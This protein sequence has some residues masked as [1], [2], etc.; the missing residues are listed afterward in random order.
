MQFRLNNWGFVNERLST[1]VAVPADDFL[2]DLPHQPD[3]KS[4]MTC[5]GRVYGVIYCSEQCRPSAFLHL[6]SILPFCVETSTITDGYHTAR[7][8][9]KSPSAES[10]TT[11]DTNQFDPP[12]YGLVDP[13]PPTPKLVQ[14]KQEHQEGD[15]TQDSDTGLDSMS[16]AWSNVNREDRSGPGRES[17]DKVGRTRL[18]RACLRCSVYNIEC[19]E[20]EPCSQCRTNM[21]P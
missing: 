2:P 18:T 12:P 3:R 14:I 17:V 11:F 13:N 5:G 21:H 19:D 8:R 9:F 10:C 20:L 1:G 16:L 15:Y 4:C 7:S 6:Y